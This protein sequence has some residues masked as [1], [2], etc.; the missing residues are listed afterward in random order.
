MKRSNSKKTH[1][2][3][4]LYGGAYLVGHELET[5]DTLPT[6][7]REHPLFLRKIVDAPPIRRR[8]GTRSGLFF[9]LQSPLSSINV[10]DR[11]RI[12]HIY[13][14][15]CATESSSTL[16]GALSLLYD[17]EKS[18]FE[19]NE[20]V[21]FS[22]CPREVASV[23]GIKDIETDFQ[24]YWKDTKDLC[25]KFPKSLLCLGKECLNVDHEVTFKAS[26]FKELLNNMKV[27]E[28]EHKSF[29]MQIMC[30]YII[31]QLLMCSRN[32]KKPRSSYWG[33]VIDLDAFEAVNW[34]QAIHNH[35]LTS[36]AEL[37]PKLVADS[38]RSKQHSFRGCAPILEVI[39]FE[40]ISSVA[41][42]FENSQPPDTKIL[43]PSQGL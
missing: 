31:E 3:R 9:F 1:E 35:L 11:G 8:D 37:K 19:L 33:L 42:K 25:K 36:I 13:Y 6:R 26:H 43:F 29:F 16:I 27:V 21:S 15:R 2:A 23:L 38:Q 4:T 32:T 40:R 12:L 14:K 24:T 41:P 39:L 5:P 28:E 30:Y 20:K 22:F 34:A 17:T 7:V 10:Q 18:L